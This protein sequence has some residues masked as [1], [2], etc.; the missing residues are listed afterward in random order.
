MFTGLVEEVGKIKHLNSGGKASILTIQGNKILED[1]KIGD[2]VAV[3]GVCLTV[4]Q[5]TGSN[6]SADVMN[7]TLKSSSLGH[8]NQ[9][10]KVSLE[11]A[12][13]VNGRFGGHFVSGHIDG[14]GQ[15]VHIKKDDNAVW[16]TL[17]TETEIARYIVKKGSIAMDGV[18]L[19]VAKIE[20]NTFSI[21][22]IPH[23]FAVTHFAEKKVLDYVNL[24]SDVIG[25]YVEKLLGFE[26][27]TSSEITREFLQKFGY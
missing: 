8:L 1:L 13:S 9:G 23:T 18:S 10:S 24:E 4:T 11:R 17:K 5:I 22:M 15:I 27:P 14:V 16:F 2:S 19:T 3:N 25:K 6:F 20:G 12:M 21:S 26:K 7:E